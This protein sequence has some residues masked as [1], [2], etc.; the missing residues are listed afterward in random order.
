[1]TEQDRNVSPGPWKWI[2]DRRLSL[3]YLP[4]LWG[5]DGAPVL[6]LGNAKYPAPGHVPSEADARLIA[7]APDLLAAA[8]AVAAARGGDHEAVLKQIDALAQ[9][10]AAIAKAEGEVDIFRLG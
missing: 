6:T 4:A 1:M 5:A 7:A 10:Q 8:K 2:T 3:G 9:L